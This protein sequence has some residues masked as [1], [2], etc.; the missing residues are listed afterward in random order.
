MLLV[1]ASL[2]PSSIHGLG[3]FAEQAIAAGELV[4]IFHEGLDVVIAQTSF[5]GLP[6]AVRA[7]LATYAYAPVD[8]PEVLVLCSDD[9]RHINHSTRPN[10]VR[11]PGDARF[12]L[13][14]AATAI[15]IGEEL[16]CDYLDFDATAHEK[17]SAPA[18]LT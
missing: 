15:A 9:A 5:E 14:V 2:R 17:L 3:C 10:V 1:R 18:N 4:W 7:Y 12:G 11:G 16:T 13:W 8:S 6:A